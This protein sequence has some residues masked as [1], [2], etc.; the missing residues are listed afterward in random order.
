MALADDFFSFSADEAGDPF[1]PAASEPGPFPE[2]PD[3]AAEIA[4]DQEAPKASRK[5]RSGKVR[6]AAARASEPE[7]QLAGMVR[8]LRAL[9]DL[10]VG[11]LGAAER[12]L[13]QLEARR[14][15]EDGGYASVE[16]FEQRMLAA[17]PILRSMRDA[18]GAASRRPQLTIAR[19]EGDARLR[20]TRALTAIARGRDRLRAIDGDIHEA[21]STARAKLHAI[22][23]TRAFDECAYTTFEEF[24]ERALGPSPVLAS[25]VA[26]V[27]DEPL[28]ATDAG[29]SSSPGRP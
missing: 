3:S 8:E 14:A 15:H 1:A 12:T 2:A 7:G 27:A 20:Q 13:V 16:E 22:E 25:A 19:R 24:L 4:A 23:A 11:K 5:G 9:E 17:T 10:I 18:A 26:L 28:P 29:R 6:H 21:A